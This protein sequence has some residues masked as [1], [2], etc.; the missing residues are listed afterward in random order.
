MNSN[1]I[2]Y[3]DIIKPDEAIN[4]LVEQLTAVKGKLAE[5]KQQAET[6]AQ[7]LSSVSG[8][9]QGGRA[10]ITETAKQTDKLAEANEKLKFAESELN[11][12]LAKVRLQIREKNQLAKLAA[13]LDGEE[14]KITNLKNESYNR[15]SAQYSL[16][17]IRL[18]AMTEEERKNTEAGQKMEQE[19]RLI[20]E[21]M[22]KLQEA[23]GM[24]QLNVGNYTNSML[25]AVG[26][27]N[28]F[29]RSLIELGKGGDVAKNA[30][31]QMQT[32][33]KAAGK[34]FTTLMANPAFLAIAGIAGAGAAF[35]WW[36]DY[37][38]GLQEATKLTAEFTGKS[39]DDLKAFRNE[40]TAIA[41]V[42]DKDWK[43]TLQAADTLAAQFGISADEALQTIKDG[44]VAGADVNGDFLQKVSQYPA[45][46]KE[47][48]L[49]AKQFVAITA[50][51]RSGIFGD[52]GLAAIKQA[53]ARI[54]EMTKGT[55]DALEQIG[56]SSKQVT[57]DLTN[58]T[59][60]TFDVLQEVAAKLAELPPSS[61]EVGETLI[62]VFGKQGRDA[63]LEM[64]KSLA[65]IS[66]NLDEVKEQTGDL[67]KLQEQQAKAEV[68]LQ[69]ALSALFDKTGGSF[70]KLTSRAKVF[71]TQALAAII[72]SVISLTN[73]V[74]DLYN[75]S[76]VIRIAWTT[77]F[78]SFKTG[79]NAIGNLF[80]YFIGILKSVGDT[81]KGAFTL[82]FDLMAQGL[83]DF[84]LSLPRL[85]KAQLK[86]VTDDVRKGIDDLNKKVKPITIPVQVGG[87]ETKPTTTQPTGGSGGGTTT[88]PK[89]KTGGKSDIA[90]T[91]TDAYKKT[92][93]LTRKMQDALLI[94]E[95]NEWEKRRKQTEY[96]YTRQI[97][98]LRA[99]LATEK[100]LTQE[101]REAINDIIIS[102]Q[103]QQFDALLRLER[104]QALEELQIQKESIDLRLDAV[105]Q[106]SEE[107]RALR[108][109]LLEIEE[110]IAKQQNL[111]S[112]SRQK[113][114]DISASFEQKRRDLAAEYLQVQLQAFEQEQELRASE[115][116]LLRNSEERKT[117][118]RIQQEKERLQKIL[119]LNA[120]AGGQLSDIEVQTIK[121]TI[122]RLDQEFKQSKAKE[123]TDIYGLFG[124]NLDNDQKE[125]INTSF[126]YAKDALNE[127]LAEITKVADA[128]VTSADKQ[129]DAAQTALNAE[130]EARNKGYASNV[131]RAQK[132]LDLARKTQQKAQREQERA[133]RAQRVMQTVEQAVNLVTAS[134]KIWAQ[135]GF[136]Y[137][138]P[139][140]AVMWGAYA[141]AKIKAAQLSKQATEQYEHGTVELLQGGSHQ[142]GN[143][144][145]L[146][147]KPDGTRR[148]A[149]G[150]EFFAVIN[151]KSSRMYRNII[152]DVINSL[153][154]GT[155]A[156][157][158]ATSE[159]AGAIA[160]SLNGSGT[161]V[162]ELNDNV[163]E[164]KKQGERRVT[165]SAGVKYEQYKNLN[166]TIYAN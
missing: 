90:T 9:T 32:N 109:E 134:T 2:K 155:F 132:D 135:L 105:R 35:K 41:D 31:Q 139:A 10:T 100:D 123:R 160:V 118:F 129:V 108:L 140:I 101:Q 156:D 80:N 36:F 58:G 7:A 103:T 145:D 70:E 144:V 146:G 47:A 154:A 27:N 163:R 78:T 6:T 4:M 66:T 93:E 39:G 124:L 3:S 149:E 50:Q 86:D 81:L 17:K 142:S 68:E 1:P 67:G 88:E 13:K 128:A 77:I 115:F 112:G 79:L 34:A 161:D 64:V 65:S 111:L 19:T 120:A 125:A 14:V 56:I 164:I 71:A 20:Y 131:E 8:A 54:R 53:N 76:L 127:Y 153:N 141:A 16:N 107:E 87:G 44:F 165:Y 62:N 133:Q 166:R 38:K 99:Q 72:K 30:F 151:K 150:G 45:A 152:P 89:K 5:L 162:T 42:F 33:V 28:G 122:K 57:E 61:K 48:G 46:F 49:S 23:T 96:Q 63:G 25:Q 85:L 137:A 52:E 40:V 138:I 130:I 22:K 116:D 51:T 37:N 119:E 74:I 91:T 43:E 158:Y 104:E 26:V 113:D 12:E 55:A 60:T 117:Q 73:Y 15:L 95:T 102:L 98:D 97:E 11:T 136:P 21:Q 126:Q 159:T 84:A 110:K 157:K 29:A 114:A 82:D 143:D 94:L 69:N 106:G 121:N 75:K 83:K 92:I 24:Y 147:V 18:N 59:R 148:R